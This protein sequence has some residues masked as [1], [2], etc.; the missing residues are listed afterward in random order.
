[1]S[2]ARTASR[3]SG[4]CGIRSSGG[5][6][7]LRLVVGIELGAEGL[8]GLVEHHREVGRPLA[9]LH[10]AQ[11]LPQHVA[12]A[13]HGVDL[14]PV[15]LAV[16]RRQRV[17]G[18]EDVARAVDQKDVVAL[19]RRATRRTRRESARFGGALPGLGLL[20]PCTGM[21]SRPS[22]MATRMPRRCTGYAATPRAAARAGLLAARSRTAPAARTGTAAAC[23]RTAQNSTSAPTMPA[24]VTS[25]EIGAD[26]GDPAGLE[27]H[28]AARRHAEEEREIDDDRVARRSSAAARTGRSSPAAPRPRPP[29]RAGEPERER[30]ERQLGEAR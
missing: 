16:E 27:Q 17:I 9:R 23:C 22:P 4:N 10:V 30:D 14:Q 29:R 18:A 20:R 12:E 6:G 15:R 21:W 7:R 11:Q 8:L 19:L 3:I 24:S 28:R 26:V 1:M 25:A 13:E 5:A 2:K